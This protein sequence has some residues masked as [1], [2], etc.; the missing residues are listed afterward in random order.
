MENYSTTYKPALEEARSSE[1]SSEKKYE[2]Y[3]DSVTAA[4]QR[5]AAAWEGFAEKLNASPLIINLVN[6]LTNLVT[7]LERW[8]PK[9]IQFF[10]TYFAY[11][12][13]GMIDSAK[14]LLGLPG[15]DFIRNVQTM[16]VKG[17]LKEAGSTIVSPA[18]KA[19]ESATMG[20]HAAWE[21]RDEKMA[22][23]LAKHDTD[24]TGALDDARAR[25]GKGA[26]TIVPVK[27]EEKPKETPKAETTPSDEG[28]VTKTAD[29]LNVDQQNQQAQQG[30]AG[31][32][33]LVPVQNQ[34][35]GEVP[36]TPGEAPVELDN[37]AA[38]KNNQ[39]ADKMGQAAIK[40]EEA[41]NKMINGA[42]Q[43]QPLGS[44]PEMKAGVTDA[45]GY[46][47]TG[48]TTQGGVAILQG[49]DGKLY[50]RKRSGMTTE[51]KT[52][53][54]EVASGIYSD[55][56]RRQMNPD[57]YKNSGR[58][59]RML[60]D[61]TNA[62]FRAI[63]ARNA[64]G[65]EYGDPLKY[66][67]T[68]EA[69]AK[70][71]YGYRSK[72]RHFSTTE[73][74]QVTQTTTTTTNTPSYTYMPYVPQEPNRVIVRDDKGEPQPPKYKEEEVYQ[75]SPKKKKSSGGK[76]DDK[77]SRLKSNAYY[78]AA[79]GV[80][81]FATNANEYG[82]QG[83]FG[84]MVG[85][86]DVK[87]DEG[88]KWG[89]AGVT[90]AGT[91]ALTAW[92]G[93]IGQ[94]L[95]QVINDFVY[96]GW[97]AL[98]HAEDKARADRV[99]A[100]KENLDSLNKMNSSVDKLTSTTA[101][102]ASEMDAL[103]FSNLQTAVDNL[104][105][106]FTSLDNRVKKSYTEEL[107]RILKGMGI[108]GVNDLNAALNKMLTTVGDNTDE[109]RKIAAAIKATQIGATATQ[110]Y[111]AA[112][113]DRN[114]AVE[115]LAK[116]QYAIV[117]RY[118]AT[119]DIQTRE[120][121][122]NEYYK[123]Y[124]E[125]I[126]EGQTGLSALEQKRDAS[127]EDYLESIIEKAIEATGASLMSDLQA[128]RTSPETLVRT[129][130][131][132]VAQD[133]L[134]GNE[135]YGVGGQVTEAFKNSVLL[136]LKANTTTNQSFKGSNI[137]LAN[138][139]GMKDILESQGVDIF[140]D[141]QRWS[142]MASAKNPSKEFQDLAKALKLT[143]DQLRD[144]IFKIDPNI[145][146][147]ISSG[148]GM[149]V[150]ELEASGDKFHWVT[151]NLVVG[152]LSDVIE[153]FDALSDAAIELTSTGRLSAESLSN[154]AKKYPS[155]LYDEKGN[156]DQQ[157][158]VGNLIEILWK[159]AA[160]TGLQLLSN[161]MIEYYETGEG[162]EEAWNVFTSDRNLGGPSANKETWRNWFKKQ[163]P[164]ANLT[165]DDL[166][167]LID[168]NTKTFADV[169]NIFLRN[170]AVDAWSDTISKLVYDIDLA[171]E[172]RDKYVEYRVNEYDK[173]IEDLN[174]I[175]DTLGDINRQREKELELL[176]AR[177]ALENAKNERKRVYRAGVG[178]TYEADQSAIAEAQEKVDQLEAQRT[179]EDVEYQISLLEQQKAILE[180]LSKDEQMEQLI[181]TMSE[182]SAKFPSNTYGLLE[183]LKPETLSNNI[184]NA[185]R[186]VDDDRKQELQDQKFETNE[187]K[188]LKEAKQ[189]WEDV[190]SGLIF[191]KDYNSFVSEK[192]ANIKAQKGTD[193][194]QKE[195]DA[196]V[197]EAQNKIYN[198]SNPNYANLANQVK[199]AGYNYSS[200]YKKADETN[201]S[202]G[203]RYKSELSG[204]EDLLK[205]D[206]SNSFNDANKQYNAGDTSNLVSVKRWDKAGGDDVLYSTTD[207]MATPTY[208]D[209]AVY[210]PG[211]GWEQ[212][213]NLTDSDYEKMP[214]GT[215]IE[216][217]GRYYHKQDGMWYVAKGKNEWDWG[218]KNLAVIYGYDKNGFAFGAMVDQFFGGLALHSW[219]DR[220]ELYNAIF[221][222]IKTG[223]T[224]DFTKE[225]V[226]R[227]FENNKSKIDAAINNSGLSREDYLSGLGNVMSGS[228]EGF[229]TF[230]G[231]Y[232]PDGKYFNF[233]SNAKG[234]LS[235][236]G[237]STLINENG[238]EGIVTPQGTLTSLP[239]RS[240]ILPADLTKNLWTLGELAP[241]L[242]SRLG[243]IEPQID[244]RNMTE[245]NSI[246]IAT[247]NATF[248]ATND[249]D[250]NKFLRDV[251]SVV[252][253]TNNL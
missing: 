74:P 66:V 92:L 117:R 16:G 43:S 34:P 1:G 152:S 115:E 237:G 227:Q 191:D 95:S 25:M 180:N 85:Y 122:A 133:N 36:A 60:Q 187:L 109:A 223:R 154:F 153:A 244:D 54:K 83:V 65:E 5:Y 93:P 67:L 79:A 124:N 140:K 130:A 225:E 178:F 57:K 184:A 221:Y 144:M 78:A 156:L 220:Q 203:G 94:V 19:F 70:I 8:S 40:M 177:D 73:L 105:S 50:T 168:P 97:K 222:Y 80:S 175:K 59:E 123:K 127:R 182:F 35:Q 103:D 64:S 107:S 208:G 53:T 91:A 99:K 201:T 82:Y 106:S 165:D 136:A 58:P 69:L 132:E 104:K 129:I 88:E 163:N 121:I 119:T 120:N 68:D 247:L 176:K 205:S 231:R 151:Q 234:N 45:N 170:G 2:A 204:Y 162:A 235:F 113:E 213:D 102:A 44:S 249:F 18:K 46:I 230:W 226:Q 110:T 84:G 118:N 174:S 238:L 210:T 96:A 160:S 49:P 111:K 71:P 229:D 233:S 167:K 134:V 12:I 27:E 28:M 41:A 179:Q 22:A 114:S 228:E 30:Q 17:A 112:E 87:L 219:Q 51:V 131:T 139:W 214:N 21:V 146:T 31:T 190:T 236:R 141:Y 100:A 142:K 181:K 61:F 248:T 195:Y 241:G 169:S 38:N 194:W 148:L 20:R 150:E 47:T 185:I 14:G 89:L 76:K 239:A 62:D 164:N 253:T 212:R 52:E 155:L 77:P 81:T 7:I 202:A 198:A 128:G 171:S 11:K 211:L 48:K 245:D 143:E 138:L 243:S 108:T 161:K 232:D 145:F 137:S 240:G 37:A 251:R 9:L 4:L 116:E 200:A 252:S 242:V 33:Q 10:S 196:I 13:P 224:P 183:A 166:A 39:A 250:M 157:N 207:E 135:V 193:D 26:P 72:A 3:S 24:Y 173:E 192:V 186:Q 23:D 216:W 63:R 86:N 55:T 199:A 101:K 217:G 98:F 206:N 90:S 246:H 56:F 197:E 209:A 126:G 32:P 29:Q 159:G 188:N 189:N 6:I 15:G 42:G 147:T 215:F 125:T 218:A 158:I 75:N 149:T 172:M